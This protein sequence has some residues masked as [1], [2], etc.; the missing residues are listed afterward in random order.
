[1]GKPQLFAN[2]QIHLQPEIFAPLIY[3]WAALAEHLFVMQI[4]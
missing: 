2:Y 4:Q 1:M 3:L